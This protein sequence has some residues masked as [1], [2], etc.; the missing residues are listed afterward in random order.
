MPMRM[1]I[2]IKPGADATAALRYRQILPLDFDIDIA[3][4]AEGVEVG[5]QADV[6]GNIKVVTVGYQN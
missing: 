5:A 6:V 1:P 4:G 3:K 2:D